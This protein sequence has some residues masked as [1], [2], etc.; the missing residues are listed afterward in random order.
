MQFLNDIKNIFYP[1]VCQACETVLTTNENVVCSQC[2][3]SLPTTNS[4]MN[5]AINVEKVFF[6]RIK[7]EHATA[8]LLYNKKGITQKLIHNLKYKGNQEIGVFLGD[9]LGKEMQVSKIF[10]NIDFIVPVPLHKKKFKKRGY[11]Q[12]EKFGIQLSIH[13]Q[14]PYVDGVLIKKEK[15]TTQSKKTRLDRWKN[16]EELFFLDDHSFF[17][18]KHILLIDDII[19]TGATIESCA[20]ELFKANKIKISIA[21]MAITE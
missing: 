10:E 16:M 9:W 4:L 17:E 6:G 14:K 3:F 13:L 15:S 11:N 18:N 5:N 1:N 2:L 7:I 21:V 20:N 19:T 12:V 8:L